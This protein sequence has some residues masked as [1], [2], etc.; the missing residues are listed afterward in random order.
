MQERVEVERE[1][2]VLVVGGESSVNLSVMAGVWI[3]DKAKR[4][5]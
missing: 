4:V 5:G 3:D 2:R 1:I